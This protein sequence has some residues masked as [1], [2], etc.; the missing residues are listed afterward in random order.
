MPLD[1]SCLEDFTID[2]D[3]I[4]TDLGK[5][6]GEPSWVAYFHGFL[7]EGEPEPTDWSEDHGVTAERFELT[8][9][10]RE[11][12]PDLQFEDFVV[13]DV[14]PSGFIYGHYGSLWPA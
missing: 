3:G 10:E 14:G 2:D 8:D 7:G 13:I 12:F 6:E 4:I 1:L 9:E 11:A 5:F